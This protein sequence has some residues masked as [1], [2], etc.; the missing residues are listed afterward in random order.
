VA[1]A[2]GPLESLENM[3]ITNQIKSFL[4]EGDPKLKTFESLA[5]NDEEE[6]DNDDDNDD[7]EVVSELSFGNEEKKKERQNKKVLL[8]RARA[9]VQAKLEPGCH[10]N[11]ISRRG[12][13]NRALKKNQKNQRRNKSKHP[14]ASIL[15]A[16]S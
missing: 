3:I 6:E 13:R 15:S 2:K 8:G 7:D 10:A 1:D 5:G 14:L 16:S 9:L 11:A 4:A 12:S